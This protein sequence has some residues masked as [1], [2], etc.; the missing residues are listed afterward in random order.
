M[1]AAAWVGLVAALVAVIAAVIAALQASSARRQAVAAEQEL[2]DNRAE[3]E[4]SSLIQGRLAAVDY[5]QAVTL[6][7]RALYGAAETGDGRDAA[8]ER[9]EAAR[10]SLLRAVNAVSNPELAEEI[11][12]LWQQVRLVELMHHR[13]GGDTDPDLLKDLREAVIL[14]SLVA[15]S[16]ASKLGDPV[17]TDPPLKLSRDLPPH[18]H[19]NGPC[20]TSCF[21]DGSRSSPHPRGAS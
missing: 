17:W 15:N 14:T 5:H 6:Y 7:V 18:D 20:M 9:E 4:R 12:N 16:L 19:G 10:A 21:S 1:D 11:I 13:L 3:R 2:A 8:S